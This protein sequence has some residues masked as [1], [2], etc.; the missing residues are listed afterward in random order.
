MNSSFV[1]TKSYVLNVEESLL[2]RHR[3]EI[4]DCSLNDL[5]P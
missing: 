2:W 3:K 1:G 4:F 5:N